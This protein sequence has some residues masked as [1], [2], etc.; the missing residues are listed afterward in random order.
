MLKYKQMFMAHMDSVGVRYTDHNDYIVKVSY[1]GDNMQSIPIYVCFD[2]EDKPLVSFKCWDVA[3]F[4]NKEARALIACN[5]MNTEYRWVKFYLDSDADIVVE[6]DAIVDDVT[7][8]E[9]C[10]Q[11]VRR[12]V[13]ITDEAYPTFARALWAA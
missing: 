3:N 8:G 10:L 12:M 6:A 2:K 1:K 13:N 5:E 11:M 7:A 4:K 9:E